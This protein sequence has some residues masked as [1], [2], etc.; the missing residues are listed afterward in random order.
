MFATLVLLLALAQP[1]PRPNV[2]E[3]MARVAENQDRAEELRSTFVYK[4]DLVVR[5]RRGNGKVAREEHRE[6]SVAPTSTGSD[7]VLERFSGRYERGG[8]LLD[9]DE[10]G[11]KYKELDIDGELIDE[12][13]DELTGDSKS[14]DG[15]TMELFPLT[16]KEQRKYRFTLEGTEEYRGRSVYRVRFKPIKTSLLDGDDGSSSLWEGEI[17]IDAAD[18]QPVFV[19]TKLA[20]G[21]PVLVQ[22]LLG[23]NIKSLGFK[24]TYE[25]FDEGLWFPVTYGAEFEIKA[26]FLY[27][28]K[29][30]IALNNSGFQRARVA[31][32]I[33]YDTPLAVERVL[34][35]PETPRPAPLKKP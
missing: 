16:S 33:D 32:R 19:S 2:A 18:L 3:I 12:M 17:L 29:I 22:A 6:Y 30:A 25:K 9:Y 21:V 15:I 8:K 26:V 11:F 10:P 1:D 7:R 24:L 4:Q 28:R 13:A 20:R 23:T 35:V 27:K 34:Q 5:F 31:T 14:R